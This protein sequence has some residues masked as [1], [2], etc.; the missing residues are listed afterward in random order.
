MLHWILHINLG[1]PTKDDDKPITRIHRRYCSRPGGV[2]MGEGF[3]TPTTSPWT[4]EPAANLVG[5]VNSARPTGVDH[6]YSVE[7]AVWLV[8]RTVIYVCL[9]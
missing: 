4:Y 2:E 8:M 9:T 7:G 5:P 3:P 6:L 1:F